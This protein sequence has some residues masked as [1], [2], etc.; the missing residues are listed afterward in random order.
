MRKLTLEEIE[1]ITGSKFKWHIN[2]IHVL[3]SAVAGFIAA[4]PFGAGIAIGAAIAAQ[5]T[6]QAHDAIKDYSQMTEPYP[7]YALGP[8]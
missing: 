8:Q 5:G 3:Y 7:Q 2:P 6:Y 1:Q 4:G